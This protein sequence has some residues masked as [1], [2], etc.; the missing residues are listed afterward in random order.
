MKNAD[1]VMQ[2]VWQAKGANVKKHQS[3]AGY[4]AYLRKRSKQEH[5]GGRVPAP[6]NSKVKSPVQD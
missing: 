3:L 4:V 5:P 2:D 1:P 6:G